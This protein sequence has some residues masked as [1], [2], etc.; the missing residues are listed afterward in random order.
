M[1]IPLT[2][3]IDIFLNT[4]R[5]TLLSSLDNVPGNLQLQGIFA[6]VMILMAVVI[7]TEFRKGREERKNIWGPF[8]VMLFCFFIMFGFSVILIAWVLMFV[9]ITALVAK[10]K[11][12]EWKGVV[13]MLVPIYFLA[14]L[15]SVN[16]PMLAL[17]V[18]GTSVLGILAKKANFNRTYGTSEAAR[19]MNE[20]GYPVKKERKIIRGLRRIAGKGYSWSKDKVLRTQSKIK[21]RLAV[22][23]LMTIE[24]QEHE[25]EIAAAGKKIAESIK[26][27]TKQEYEIEK[28]DMELVGEILSQCQRLKSLTAETSEQ[29]QKDKILVVSKAILNLSNKLV[30]NKMEDEGLKEKANKILEQ[31]V[32]VIEKSSHEIK[33]LKERKGDFEELRKAAVQDTNAIKKRLLENLKSIDHARKSADHEKLKVLQE[34][35]KALESVEKRVEEISGYISAIIKRLERINIAEDQRAKAVET[36]SAKAESHE[37]RLSGYHHRFENADK[38]LK[39]EYKRFAHLFKEEA[40]YLPDEELVKISGSTVNMFNWLRNIALLSYEY[41]AKELKPLITDMAEVA[42]NISYL[43]KESE[44]LNKMYYRLS[45]AMESLTD[46]A[47]TVEMDTKAKEK[48]TK[49]HEAEETEEKLER[50]AY[51]KGMMIISYITHGYKALVEANS[52]LDHYIQTTHRYGAT[53]ESMTKEVGLTLNNAFRSIEIGQIKQA[54]QMEKA[55]LQAEA[56]LRKGKKAEKAAARAV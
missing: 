44:Y 21:Q 34:K 45:K 35:H 7:I 23:E 33:Q 36:I 42:R 32:H 18:G 49:I 53:I 24:K 19:M 48:L 43:S 15:T 56:Q 3:D 1:A 51:K 40:K 13:F 20:Q 29:R 14:Y 38:R 26:D 2:S 27:F 22:R 4:Q 8:G 10:L 11:Q 28:R 50:R 41:N 37:K 47:T 46:I 5:V 17:L 25:A 55:A 39:D 31:C 6:F 30:K 54:K 12:G 16:T 52:Y 9:L